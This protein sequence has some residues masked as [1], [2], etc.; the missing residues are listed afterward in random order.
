VPKKMQFPKE[1]EGK[2]LINGYDY[3]TIYRTPVIETGSG[4]YM[5]GGGRRLWA[6]YAPFLNR[7]GKVRREN[8][9]HGDYWRKD[10]FQS[11]DEAVAFCNKQWK[12]GTDWMPFKLGYWVPAP[13]AEYADKPCSFPYPEDGTE[14]KYGLY[15]AC[16]RRRKPGDVLC[17]VHRSMLNKRDER[18]R[19]REEADAQK[20]KD[21][22]ESDRRCAVVDDVIELLKSID[23]GDGQ[24]IDAR[25][26]HPLSDRAWYH[27][28]CDG[29]ISLD[30][31]QARALAMR[32]KD[33]DADGIPEWLMR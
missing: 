23:L 21:Q 17:G 12:T 20:T 7:E 11:F 13:S 33:L 8:D 32:L 18:A 3:A 24:E 16:S 28:N 30:V 1:V 14:V 2:H 10:S 27:P 29:R 6:V 4:A 26:T 9:P 22:A 31:E 5:K 15:D 25:H 19:A